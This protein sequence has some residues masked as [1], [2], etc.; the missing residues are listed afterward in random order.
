MNRIKDQW[1]LLAELSSSLLQKSNLVNCWWNLSRSWT[2]PAGICLVKFIGG[3]SLEEGEVKP[4]T[5]KID[6]VHDGL[7]STSV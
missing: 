3:R 4:L 5:M 7:E 6:A 1:V 2:W